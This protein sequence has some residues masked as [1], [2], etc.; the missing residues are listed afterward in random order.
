MNAIIDAAI[1][2]SRTVIT[3][4]IVA[5]IVGIGS[6]ISLPKEADPDIA[7]PFI[8]VR[9]VHEGISP[10]DAER[11]LVKPLEQ[12]L[13]SVDGIKEMRSIAAENYAYVIIEFDAAFDP[14]KARD[15]IR[16][17]VD[18][19][20]P[21]F[22]DA[23]E[24][25]V[26]EE[27]NASLFPVI[28]ITLS[29]AVPERLLRYAAE[30]VEEHVEALPMILR[31]SIVGAREELLEIVIDPA[32]LEAYNVSLD[33]LTRAAAMNNRLIPAGAVQTEQAR[34]AVKV[35][36]LFETRE[37]V[38]GLPIKASGDGV[39]TLGDI[40]DI[41][42]TFKDV[43]SRARVN[44]KPAVAVWAVKR[45]NENAVL[46]TEAVR[47]V[48]DELRPQLPEGL[49]IHYTNDQSEFVNQTQKE[50]QA[51]VTTA[52]V[53]VMII[54][55]AALG[56]RSGLLVGFAIPSSFMVGFM[57]LGM[58]GETV[59]M[60]VMFGLVL[61]VGLLVD[62]AIVVVELADRKMAE[63]IHRSEAYAIAAKR[64]AWPIISSTATTLAA[65]LPL[66]F[67]PGVS[68]EFMSYLPRT[69]IIIL[70]ASLVVAMIFLPVFGSY[71]GKAN[72]MVDPATLKALSVSEHGDVRQL[73]GLTGLYA[74]MLWVL[75]RRPVTVMAVTIAVLGGIFWA[76]G[77]FGAGVVY[78][79]ASQPNEAVIFVGARGNLGPHR[80]EE[81]VRDVEEIVISEPGI[82][83]AFT[84]V[85]TELG[86]RGM[87]LPKDTIGTINVE[88]T[89]W[90]TRRK[91]RD[92]LTSIR[93]RTKQLAGITVSVQERHQGPT[94]Q[95][96][97]NLQFASED[98]DLLEATV[99]RFRYLID[100]GIDG[101][102][103]LED[104]R[105][106]PGIDWELKIDREQAARFGLDITTVGGVVQLMTNGLLIG[107]YRPDDAPEEIDIRARFDSGDR[108]IEALDRLRVSTPQGPVPITNFVTRVPVERVNEINRFNG[109]RHM[110]IKANPAPGYLANDLVPEIQALVEREGM[111]D[112][113]T[114][115]Y[116]GSNEEQKESQEFLTGAMMASLFLMG[117]ILITQFNN[118]YHAV[119]ILSSI[120]LSTIGALL[121]LLLRDQTFSI[122]LTGTGIIALA[123]I[124]VNNNIVLVDTYQYLRKQGEEPIDAIVRT[125]AQR[126][127]P[128]MLTTITTICGVLPMAYGWNI[129]FFSR[130]IT[131]GAPTGEWWV[132]LATAIVYG[133]AFA[134]VLTL[135]VTPCMIA[136][137]S[138]LR[139][140]FGKSKPGKSKSGQNSSQGSSQGS[141]KGGSH[142]PAE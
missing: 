122:I 78:F 6:Y 126:L 10:E 44:G 73:G 123:G 109:V 9:V 74:R 55:V 53:L 41:R 129:D 46:A 125:G 21:E 128:V 93:E 15:D 42:R 139:D 5:L 65:F 28:G 36:G 2:R 19:A 117:I 82:G 133:L 121:G 25:P 137:P 134:T 90:Q 101:L 138:V 141:E 92:I 49:E 86:D 66:L 108:S 58:M 35:P 43:E 34:F 18:L 29:G 54:V 84:E 4:F 39:V 124:V 110:N 104:T 131:T 24:E 12:E 114:L 40:A 60:M 32:K 27:F 107:E 38:L 140:R 70:T 118:F 63:G 112:G 95:K 64:M 77:K 102:V 22:P 88:F 75:V 33:E 85:G 96:E 47:H 8:G 62:G 130:E 50:L 16:D 3:A 135:I 76:Y 30:L 116:R 83:I 113:V 91:A 105:P 127:R 120:V 103:D 68:G 20:K 17:R 7:I 45:L 23:A 67:W 87:D 89:D 80:A 111:P 59:N 119:L 142:Q 11:L 106:V 98:I 115:A 100:T 71:F 26:I 69:L 57:L 81:L 37:D 132:Q 56:L 136:M 61:S 1:Q 99:A 97:I 14:D 51:S 94:P 13:R 79:N 48:V 72:S 31:A 52:I